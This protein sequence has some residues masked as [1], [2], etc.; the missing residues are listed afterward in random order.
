MLKACDVLLRKSEWYLGL[1]EANNLEEDFSTQGVSE[2]KKVALDQIEKTF[3]NQLILLSEI[4][5]EELELEDYFAMIKLFYRYENDANYSLTK[6]TCSNYDSDYNDIYYVQGS[7]NR[8]YKN[9]FLKYLSSKFE[10]S[11]DYMEV[12][13]GEYMNKSDY[14]FPEVLGSQKQ[15]FYQTLFQMQNSYDN[16]YSLTLRK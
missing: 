14:Q 10:M 16:P 8:E 12:V 13:Y 4:H 7:R 1:V 5:G 3:F 9:I 15:E 2:L 11:S 6:V